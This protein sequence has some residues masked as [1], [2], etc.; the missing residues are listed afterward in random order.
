MEM[1]TDKDFMAILR[2][3]GLQV[4]YQRV[5]IYRALCSAGGHPSAELIHERVK[6]QFPALALGTVYK[7]L[8][9]FCEVG[10]I[11]KVSP[12]TEVTRYDAEPG[13]HHYMI[14]MR[15]QSVQNADSIIGEPKVSV[16]EIKGL[17]PRRQQV[18][19]Y[20]YCST[21]QGS[22]GDPQS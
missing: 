18:F 5:A 21:C 19:L 2:D 4:T 12:I 11:Q 9:R 15:C 7:T 3:H 8:E 16:S 1:R 22:S 14:C 6:E 13:L 17:Q 10:L 20:G